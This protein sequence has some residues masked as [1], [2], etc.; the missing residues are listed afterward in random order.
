ME[1]EAS[2][3]ETDKTGSLLMKSPILNLSLT[4]RYSSSIQV[5]NQK[6]RYFHTYVLLIGIPS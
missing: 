1:I 6:S 4:K 2:T 3:Q 5:V